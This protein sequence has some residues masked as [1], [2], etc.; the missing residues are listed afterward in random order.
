MT[1][2]L[3]WPDKD[4][5][6][7]WEIHGFLCAY[8]RLDHGRRMA[9]KTKGERPDYV[10]EDPISGDTMG[11]ELTSVYSDDNSVPDRHMKEREGPI[12]IPEDSEELELYKRRLLAAV[13]E[14]VRKARSGYDTSR[15]L[16]L[17]VYVNEYISIHMKTEDWKHLV[18]NNKSLFDDMAPFDEV[19]FW[20][21]PDEGVFSVRPGSEA[22]A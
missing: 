14:K 16:V 22:A 21:L 13:Q 18:E 17:A 9:V 4:K 2:H 6:E 11:V 15:P 19:V 8:E 3:N 10:V 20:D 7:R 12:P 1:P 5:R